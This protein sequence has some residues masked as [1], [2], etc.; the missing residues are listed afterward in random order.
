MMMQDPSVFV[1][2]T[3]RRQ[4]QKQ[5]TWVWKYGTESESNADGTSGG[6]E[7]EIESRYV[8]EVGDDVRFKVRMV[9]FATAAEVVASATAAQKLEPP[10]RPGKTPTAAVATTTSSTSAAVVTTA[11]VA[12]PKAVMQVLG[13]TNDFGLGL[14]SWW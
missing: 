13:C 9:N 14:L 10:G 6:N 7:G 8:M 3:N 2:S 5:G 11:E 1:P 4:D 12:P